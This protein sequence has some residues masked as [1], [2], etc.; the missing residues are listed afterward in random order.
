MDKRW[1]V[2]LGGGSDLALKTLKRLHH[3][4]DLN[5]FVSHRGNNPRLEELSAQLG[6][7]IILHQADLQEEKSLLDMTLRI[8]EAC[9]VPDVLVQ[10]AAPALEIHRFSETTNQT[11]YSAFAVQTL[12][13]LTAHFLLGSKPHVQHNGPIDAY[14]YRPNDSKSK[15]KL[16]A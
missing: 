2:F 7:R 11:L 10:F 9:G 14:L 13:E 16:L 3:R 8:G 6:K 1:V 15:E 5:F 4:D 12:A